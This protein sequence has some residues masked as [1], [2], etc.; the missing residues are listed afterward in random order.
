[1][2]ALV[3]GGAVRHRAL[4]HLVLH[5]P[6]EEKYSFIPNKETISN[7]DPDPGGKK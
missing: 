5:H 2:K 6:E 7:P 3:L 4:S 1:V